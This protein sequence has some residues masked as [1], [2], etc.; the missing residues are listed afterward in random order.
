MHGH[1]RSRRSR[2]ITSLNFQPPKNVRVGRIHCRWVLSTLGLWF[3]AGREMKYVQ[4][5]FSPC[6]RPVVVPAL[7]NDAL[8]RAMHHSVSGLDPILA[9]LFLECEQRSIRLIPFQFLLSLCHGV[10]REVAS[11]SQPQILLSRWLAA[12]PDP[13]ATRLRPREGEPAHYS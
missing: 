10:A 5:T 12:A 2:P 7:G 3:V 4:I 13:V 6:F 8:P 1:H 9:G 11:R